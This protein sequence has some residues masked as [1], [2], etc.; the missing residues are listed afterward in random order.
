MAGIRS[1]VF[2]RLAGIRFSRIPCVPL[3]L[4]GR[5]RMVTK[6]EVL[7]GEVEIFLEGILK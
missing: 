4:D 5:A 3:S 1:T 6:G 7:Q 2:G